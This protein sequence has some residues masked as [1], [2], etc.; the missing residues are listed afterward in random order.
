MEKRDPLN[1]PVPAHVDKPPKIDQGKAKVLFG[2]LARNAARSV[3]CAGARI[4]YVEFKRYMARGERQREGEFRDFYEAV[5]FW[6]AAAENVLLNVLWEDAVDKKNTA[7]AKY[8]LERRFRRR[9]APNVD[10]SRPIQ[11]VPSPTDGHDLSAQLDASER[12]ARIEALRAI[13]SERQAKRLAG[14]EPL[15]LE[16]AVIDSPEDT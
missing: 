2:L 11:A 7:S 1:V 14:A 16:V 9:W 6:E 15:E 12:L 3:A 4:P 10:P 13:A 5:L 8:L